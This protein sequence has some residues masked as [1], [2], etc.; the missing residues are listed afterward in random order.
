MSWICSTISA[1]ASVVTSPSGRPRATS[2]SNLRMILPE[3]VF[4]R[5][6]VKMNSLR[7]GDRTDHLRNVLTQFLGLSVVPTFWTP[8]G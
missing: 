2:R 3:R 5:S 6:V 4:G 8:S 1:F 7:G